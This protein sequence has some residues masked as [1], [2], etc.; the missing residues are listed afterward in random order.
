M[1]DADDDPVE[2]P[3]VCT[4]CGTETRVAIDDLAETV[5]SHN[6]RLHGGEEVASVD[7]DLADHLLDL[8]ADDLLASR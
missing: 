7:P 5:A 1:A 3:V 8:V 4:E 6:E 2:V